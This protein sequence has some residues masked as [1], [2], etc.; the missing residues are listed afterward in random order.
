MPKPNPGRNWKSR[1][2]FTGIHFFFRS[3]PILLRGTDFFP[4]HRRTHTHHHFPPQKFFPRFPWSER[5]AIPS[6]PTMHPDRH[7]GW[8]TGPEISLTPKRQRFPINIFF[9]KTKTLFE[10][11]FNKE[12]WGESIFACMFFNSGPG[13]GCPGQIREYFPGR[14]LSVDRTRSW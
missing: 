14:S 5:P 7:T 2:F 11:I 10:L 13:N 1:I 6:A 12:I 8:K 9:K 3:A 4:Y